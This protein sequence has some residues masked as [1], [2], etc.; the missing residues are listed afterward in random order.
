MTNRL[1]AR[2]ELPASAAVEV[3]AI[4]QD[5]QQ[6][7]TAIRRNTALS[8][9]QRDAQLTDLSREVT[10]KLSST[11]TPNGLEAYK[12]YGGGWLQNLNPPAKVSKPVP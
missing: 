3:V 4:Q 5:A 1:V 12:Q 10:G 6:R 8:T 7:L 9:D 2:L 11:L